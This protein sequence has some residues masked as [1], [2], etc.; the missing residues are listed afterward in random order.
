[1]D[2]DLNILIKNHKPFLFGS[3]EKSTGVDKDGKEF[4][5]SFSTEKG[6]VHYNKI[7]SGDYLIEITNLDGE[8]ENKIISLDILTKWFYNPSIDFYNENIKIGDSI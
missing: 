4:D 8:K 1:M 5:Y 3:P 6:R 2:A 7:D